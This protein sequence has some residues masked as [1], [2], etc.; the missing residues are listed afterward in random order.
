[1]ND[2]F[3]FRVWDCKEKKYVFFNFFSY[4]ETRAIEIG[5][6]TDISWSSCN[7]NLIDKTYHLRQ[8]DIIE[9]CTGLKDMGDNIAYENDFIDSDG[10]LYKIIFSDGAFVAKPVMIDINIRIP[11]KVLQPFCVVGTIH[12]YVGNI[13]D[14]G[15][16]K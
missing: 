2:R 8:N 11:L 13:H 3:K 10:V 14:K 15:D 12:N 5:L 1:M 6:I 16:V 4:L 9:Q 7:D